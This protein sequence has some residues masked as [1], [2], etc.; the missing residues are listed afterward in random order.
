MVRSMDVGVEHKVGGQGRWARPT[1]G[2]VVLDELAG[3]KGKGW[4]AEY[5]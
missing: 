4:V 3:N 2:E 1:I 5:G